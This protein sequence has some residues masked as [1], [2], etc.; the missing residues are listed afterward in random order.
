M[1]CSTHSE[2]PYA[3]SIVDWVETTG[4]QQLQAAYGMMFVA[5]KRFEGRLLTSSLPCALCAVGN[6]RS[7]DYSLLIKSQLI[8][9]PI[10]YWIGRFLHCRQPL[11]PPLAAAS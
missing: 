4:Q 2:G 5:T 1:Q 8:G 7:D 9:A 3:N 11:I 6:L 10:G